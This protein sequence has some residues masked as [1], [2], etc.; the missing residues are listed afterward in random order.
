MKFKAINNFPV[1]IAGIGVI[2]KDMIFDVS[3]P[4]IIR[5]FEMALGMFEVLE[6]EEVVKEDIMEEE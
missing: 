1:E 2:K 5:R 3:N 6:E 4:K